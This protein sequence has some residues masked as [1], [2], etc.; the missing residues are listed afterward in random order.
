[1]VGPFRSPKHAERFII[2][3]DWFSGSNP[4]DSAD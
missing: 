2:A 3:T 1:M 4:A